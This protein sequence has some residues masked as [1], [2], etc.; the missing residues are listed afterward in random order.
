MNITVGS[1]VAGRPG[2]GAVAEN[3]HLISELQ[4]ERQ[5]R[6]SIGKGGA[7]R[8]GIA[9]KDTPYKASRTF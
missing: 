7:A 5:K 1:I 6:G 9:T 3:S 8:Q 2:A 4:A